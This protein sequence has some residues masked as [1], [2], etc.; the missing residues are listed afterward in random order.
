[1]VLS[2]FLWFI[3]CDFKHYLFFKDHSMI[4]LSGY[5]IHSNYNFSLIIIYQDCLL[6]F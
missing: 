1:M 6:L 5:F 2:L 3:S 4:H